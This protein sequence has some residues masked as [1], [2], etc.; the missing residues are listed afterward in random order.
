MDVITDSKT[1]RW[2]KKVFNFLPGEGL[3]EKTKEIK[4]AD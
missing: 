3:Y 4:A 2:H 1:G